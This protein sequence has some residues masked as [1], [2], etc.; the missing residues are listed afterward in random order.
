MKYVKYLLILL[1]V[2]VL[3]GF[4]YVATQPSDYDVTRS[5]VIKAPVTK[6]FNTVNN[7]K[8]WEKW[9]PWH[10][11][12][13]TIVVTHGDTS[14]GIG[15]NNSWTSKDGPGKM[16]TVALET[17]KSIDQKIWMMDLEGKGD[18]IYW[19]FDEVEG[20][21]KVTWGMKSNNAPFM[22]KL[23]AV[24]MGGFDAM[25][26]PMEESGLNNLAKVVA[27]TPD[28]YKLSEVSKVKLEG[29]KF[30][31]YP[32]KMKINHEA[33]TKAFM[34]N[35]PKAGMYAMKSGLKHGDFLPASVYTKYDEQTGETEFY[36]GLIL[37]KDLKPAEGMME[38]NIPAGDALKISKF[39]QYGTGD[40]EAH[41]A[42]ANF[43]SKNKM[44]QSFPIWETFP[45]DPMKVKP[46]DIQTDIYY[47]VK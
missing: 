10:D 14:V 29:K 30:I 40:F 15:A 11:E 33:M 12:D 37:N 25:L 43:L 4:G 46:E 16:E 42:L 22:F 18:D 28:A 35:M 7:L 26:G 21:T 1:V 13:S 31:G 9:G 34:E 39:G 45:N 5:K 2:L 19:K 27:D 44:E 36:I 20:G 3:L 24:F 38:L 8:T 6:V 17:N 32:I 41:T 23:I 47:P